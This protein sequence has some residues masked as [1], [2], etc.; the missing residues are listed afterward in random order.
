MIFRFTNVDVYVHNTKRSVHAKHICR[1]VQKILS[2]KKVSAHC[3]TSG[4]TDA[5]WI[6]MV[7]QMANQHVRIA[8]T[9][10]EIHISLVHQLTF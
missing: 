8:L 7:N 5:L 6:C 3:R 9:V 10:A 2:A 1:N 4:V